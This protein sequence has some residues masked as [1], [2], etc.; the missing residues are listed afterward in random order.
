MMGASGGGDDMTFCAT[1]AAAA[2]EDWFRRR[3]G[4]W[5]LGVAF[6]CVCIERARA[7]ALRYGHVDMCD[8]DEVCCRAMDVASR[9]VRLVMGGWAVKLCLKRAETVQLRGW[10][11]VSEH[12]E[13]VV[14]V[15]WASDMFAR[16][17]RLDLEEVKISMTFRTLAPLGRRTSLSRR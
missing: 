12:T 14:V 7:A 8:S 1:W 13:W 4:W 2:Q 16:S 3:E 17:Y 10:S 9:G 15:K 11:S 5:R 6:F